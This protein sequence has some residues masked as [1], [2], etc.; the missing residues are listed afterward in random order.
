MDS[1]SHRYPVSCTS[2]ICHYSQYSHLYVLHKQLIK[3]C[4]FF[5]RLLASKILIS[6]CYSKREPSQ[7][8]LSNKIPFCLPFWF[9][10]LAS[11]MMVLNCLTESISGK[12]MGLFGWFCSITM[13][14]SG[15]LAWECKN[16]R[17]TLYTVFFFAIPCLLSLVQLALLLS[18]GLLS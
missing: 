9:F 4:V 18:T 3:L 13:N 10:Y 2:T 1:I 16:H 5:L 7:D 14:D 15:G 11:L 17:E 8:L 12:G 6:P